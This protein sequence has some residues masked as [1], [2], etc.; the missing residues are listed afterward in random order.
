LRYC[1]NENAEY[2]LYFKNQVPIDIPKSQNFQNKILKSNS[3]FWF[4]HILLPKAAK[5]DK[6][7]IFFSPSYILPFKMSEKIK[8][9]VAIHD[10]SYEAHPEWYSWQ[11]RILLRWIG[12]KSARKADIIFTCSEFSKNEVL[13]YYRI[14][15]DKIKVIYLAADEKFTQNPA[16]KKQKLIFYVGAIFNRRFIPQII[17]AFKKIKNKLPDY[18]LLIAGPNYT[19]PHMDIKSGESI[20]YNNY[21][22]EKDLVYL[23]NSASLFVWLSSYEGFGL[24]PLEAMACGTPVLSNKKTSLSEVL[25][26]YPISVENPKDIDEIS[27]KMLKVLSNEQLSD[28]LIKKGLEQAQKFSWQKTAK[29]TLK[30]LLSY[31]K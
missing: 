11:N 27:E 10:L 28:G 24:P 30:I 6:V 13:K 18:Q 19:Y 21:I 29:E 22:D 1:A 26:D 16:I 7:D 3:N 2:V 8:T 5:Q 9:A 23:Y 15:A 12:K 20:I 17:Q 25:G 4:E 14:A 31:A